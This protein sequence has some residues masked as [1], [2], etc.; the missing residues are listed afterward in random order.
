[1]VKLG[2]RLSDQ[3]YDHL[4]KSLAFRANSQPNA[5][6]PPH[7]AGVSGYTS[8]LF[9]DFIYCCVKIQVHGNIY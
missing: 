3:F 4:L 2:Y 5:P 9:D 7:G 6:K 1:M 8:I